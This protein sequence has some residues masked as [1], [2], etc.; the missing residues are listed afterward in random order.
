MDMQI[1]Q[2]ACI[3]MVARGFHNPMK[4]RR[5]TVEWSGLENLKVDVDRVRRAHI[6]RPLTNSVLKDGDAG[7]GR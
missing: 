4:P 1:R 2:T 6:S 3:A 5:S 7:A